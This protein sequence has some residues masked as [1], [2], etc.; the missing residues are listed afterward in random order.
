LSAVGQNRAAARLGRL[1]ADR[2]VA[3]AFVISGVLTSL[4][5]LVLGAYVGGAFLDMGQ[6]HLLQSVAAVVVGGTLIFGGLASAIGVFFGNVLLILV[7]TLTQ[8]MQ[9]PHG[10]RDM[11]QA[12]ASFLCSRWRDTKPIGRAAPTRSGPRY[13]LRCVADAFHG[14]LRQCEPQE[15]HA[16]KSSKATA[17][18]HRFAARATACPKEAANL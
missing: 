5:E 17:P 12:S 6:P 7:V 8:I 3:A 4:I 16:H 11:V 18:Q 15:D 1:P 14:D 9:L 2:V 13:R 10:S